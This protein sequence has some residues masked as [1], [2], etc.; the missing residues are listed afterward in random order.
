MPIQDILRNNY[1]PTSALLKLAETMPQLRCFTYV[2]TAFVNANLPKGTCIQEQLYPLQDIDGSPAD[3]E[4]IAQRLLALPHKKADEQV[5]GSCGAAP[6]LHAWMGWAVGAAGRCCA[7][8]AGPR[9][10][11]ALQ[12]PVAG[13]TIPCP[14]MPAWGLGL[15]VKPAARQCQI[16]ALG[17]LA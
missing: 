6:H 12:L 4:A 5:R 9:G 3:V 14:A 1:L 10:G 7:G 2:S 17:S 15:A 11:C 16:R 8:S 13:V